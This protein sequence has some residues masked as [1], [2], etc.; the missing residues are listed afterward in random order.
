MK[1][2]QD[3]FKTN[4][5]FR[6]IIRKIRIPED[7]KRSLERNKQTN[8]HRNVNSIS[9]HSHRDWRKCISRNAKEYDPRPRVV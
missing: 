5:Q 6:G 1:N 4:E 8:G 7:H 3:K 2:K 9:T